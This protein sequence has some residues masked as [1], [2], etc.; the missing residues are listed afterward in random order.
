[1]ALAR[2]KLAPLGKILLDL[3]KITVEQLSR[4]LIV[5]REKYPDRMVGEILVDMGYLTTD[6]LHNALAL[7]FHYPHIQIRKY[8]LDKK[9]LELIPKEVAQRHKLI[10]LDKFGK[11]ITIA[12]FNPLDKEALKTISEITGLEVRAFVSYREELDE[13]INLVY[14]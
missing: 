12:M 1:M 10:P 13:T 7:Q 5:Q 4:V 14:R 11:I 8:K 9:I 2:E 3:K 6:D